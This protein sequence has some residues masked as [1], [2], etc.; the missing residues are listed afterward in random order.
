MYAIRSYYD[1][2]ALGVGAKDEWPT[3]PFMEYM[4]ALESGSGAKW[5]EMAATNTPFENGSDV[6]NAYT[7]VY[8]LFKSGVCGK[9][10]LG[11][12]HD[13]LA[14]LFY[15]KKVG[16]MVFAP[17]LYAAVKDAGVDVSDLS[18]FYLPTR[19]SE[20]DDF[21]TL[22]AVITSYSIHYTKLYEFLIILI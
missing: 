5:T 9:D 15:D 4:P 10:P 22:V 12:G 18:T 21:R 11:V 6:Y 8:N 20:N 1:F 17:S 3:Y 19:N 13:Q 2:I 7:K 16:M 14:A